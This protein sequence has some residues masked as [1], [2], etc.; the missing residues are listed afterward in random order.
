MPRE[1]ITMTQDEVRAFL[2]GRSTAVLVTVAGDHPGGELV[3]ARLS[4]DEVVVTVSAAALAAVAADPRVCVIVED[5]PTFAGIRGVLVHGTAR[6][7][8]D[9]T[10]AVPLDDVASFDFGKLRVS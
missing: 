8:G 2:A 5:Q 4:G 6:A 10:L 9:G 3:R 1:D 7:D